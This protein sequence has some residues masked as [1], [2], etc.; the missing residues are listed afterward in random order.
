M[1]AMT[2][3]GQNAKV[4]GSSYMSVCYHGVLLL[5][6]AVQG[7]LFPLGTVEFWETPFAGRC[8]TARCFARREIG[9][10]MRQ[11]PGTLV[12]P[13][14]VL[15]VFWRWVVSLQWCTGGLRVVVFSW[16]YVLAIIGGFSKSSVLVVV[17]CVGVVVCW[18]F[19]SVLL[20]FSAGDILLV[21]S[22]WRVVFPPPF[23]LPCSA[24]L[25]F[26]H[27]LSLP[28]MLTI[29]AWGIHGYPV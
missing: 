7:F 8:W 26:H 14:G 5:K 27:P 9:R 13:G 28:W 2:K 10:G 21:F 4:P 17:F 1:M 3:L 16:W 12:L 19:G 29:L 23:F 6:G 22:S 18:W 11:A 15:M 20:A 24:S 25:Y